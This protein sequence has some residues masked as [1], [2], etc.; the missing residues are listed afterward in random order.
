MDNSWF[1]QFASDD[2]DP[3]DTDEDEEFE[4]NLD[5]LNSDDEYDSEDSDAAFVSQELREEAAVQPNVLFMSKDKTIEYSK[6]PLPLSHSNRL[7]TSSFATR[8]GETTLLLFFMPFIALLLF[9][10]ARTNSSR[11]FSSHRPIVRFFI[12]HRVI[13]KDRNRNDEFRRRSP[14]QGRLESC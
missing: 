9:Y 1:D 8:Q 4:P 5:E 14:I 2:S 12:I 11:R 6:D 3:F 10:Y 7:S 13:R